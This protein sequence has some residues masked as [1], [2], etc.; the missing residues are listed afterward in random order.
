M[1]V[2]GLRLGRREGC[3]A[4]CDCSER[5]AANARTV[6]VVLRA[7]VCDCSFVVLLAAPK[8]RAHFVLEEHAA[9]LQ[10]CYDRATVQRALHGCH[11]CLLVGSLSAKLVDQLLG[12]RLWVFLVAAL[13][14]AAR[15]FVVSKPESS[16]TSLK[17]HLAVNRV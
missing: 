4:D 2:F 5:S 12:L 9:S 7:T 1:Q 6:I 3:A 8:A 15:P 17:D 13:V 14:H 11:K 10:V 16:V